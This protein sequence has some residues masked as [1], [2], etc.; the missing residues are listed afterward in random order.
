VGVGPQGK[1]GIAAFGEDDVWIG[2]TTPLGHQGFYV[3]GASHWDGASWTN[4]RIS[5]DHVSDYDTVAVAGA[6]GD[7]VWLATTNGFDQGLGRTYTAHFDGSAW[8]VVPSPN[9]GTYP[10]ELDAAAVLGD[11]SVWAAGYASPFSGVESLVLRYG[12]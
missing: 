2:Y 8:A 1:L 7:D 9:P 12:G 11:G 10:D 4:V 5:P 6:S 3:V